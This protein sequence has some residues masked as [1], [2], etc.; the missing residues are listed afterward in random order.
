MNDFCQRQ[1]KGVVRPSRVDEQACT[2]LSPHIVEI[3]AHTIEINEQAY[4]ALSHHIVEIDLV[5]KPTSAFL[6]ADMELGHHPRSAP[7]K[8]AQFHECVCLRTPK[9]P[10]RQLV[11]VLILHKYNHAIHVA[12]GLQETGKGEGTG[13]V[14]F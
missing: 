13:V 5:H 9:L 3:N 12:F 14:L 10:A 8:H 1:K 6:N 2:A 4:T 11:Y 7:G